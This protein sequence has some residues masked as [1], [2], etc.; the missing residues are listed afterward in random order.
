MKTPEPTVNLE[1]IADNSP[2]I[3]TLPLRELRTDGDTQMRVNGL[4][5]DS[6]NDYAKKIRQGAQF[7]AL[8]AVF[9]G[10]QNWLWDGFHTHAALVLVGI[11]AYSVEITEGTKDDAILLGTGANDTHG[12][13]R[14]NADKRNSVRSIL[15]QPEWWGWSDRKI[16]RICKV[17]PPLIKEVREELLQERQEAGEAMLPM[18]ATR[19]VKRNGRTYQMNTAAI[20]NGKPGKPQEEIGGIAAGEPPK[21]TPLPLIETGRKTDTAVSTPAKPPAVELSNEYASHNNNG[22]LTAIHDTPHPI[23]VN[24][25]ICGNNLDVMRSWPDSFIQVVFTSSPYPKLRGFDLDVP[26]WLAWIE[27]RIAEVS[28]ILKPNGVF[29]LNILFPRKEDEET[30]K[31]KW[32]DE[33]LFTQMLP[34]ILQHGFFLF[35][36]Y[37]WFKI[38]PVP[39][40]NL[41]EHDI[42][43]WEPVFVFA[44]SAEMFFDPVHGQY[45]QKTL[46]RLVSGSPRGNGTVNSYSGGHA[47]IE[48]SGARQHNVIIASP[49]AD[50]QGM[51]KAKGGGFPP[52]VPERFIRQHSQPGDLI[53]D[54]FCGSGPTL[55][56]AEEHGRFWI[57]LDKDP[58]PIEKSRERLKIVRNRQRK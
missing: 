5:N 36:L 15:S 10:R 31:K 54:I 52:S 55:Q 49:S 12:R 30:R 4:D 42:S 28:R 53:V 20:A 35:D 39:S 14:T 17:S 38:N 13:K 29:G 16:A 34:M 1:L 2:E 41:K 8:K 48:A 46:A 9:D 21:G 40:G 37:P 44:K 24:D 57:G 47:R 3:K 32:F 22:K 51:P 58:T 27:P 33:R 50:D 11:D 43:A 19:T 56:A 45:A 18:P 7:P 26:E 23:P 6:V 25:L